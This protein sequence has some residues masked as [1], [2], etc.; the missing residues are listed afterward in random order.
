VNYP[1]LHIT[2]EIQWFIGIAIYYWYFSLRFFVLV[3]LLYNLMKK[4]VPFHFI[5]LE[6]DVELK[7]KSASEPIL[8]ICFQLYCD[9]SANDFG[10]V[11]IQK[12]SVKFFRSI[13]YFSKRPN[14]VELKYPNHKLECLVVY[15]IKWFY[16]YLY[17]SYVIRFKIIMNYNSFWHLL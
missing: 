6:N 7:N 2:K 17:L 11:L 1:N 5:R 15:A 16:I 4:N 13:F 9:A 3:K 14:V 10:A 12:Q 8:T